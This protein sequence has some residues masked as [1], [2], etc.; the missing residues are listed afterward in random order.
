MALGLGFV[1]DLG[2]DPESFV[3]PDRVN[4]DDF[5]DNFLVGLEDPRAELFASEDAF[6]ET[7]EGEVTPVDADAGGDPDES[8]R[9]VTDD[10]KIDVGL[11]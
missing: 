2:T 8:E 11:E 10:L 1:L 9:T 4:S 7:G 6:E 3:L 5:F